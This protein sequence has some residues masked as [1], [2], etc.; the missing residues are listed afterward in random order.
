LATIPRQASATDTEVPVWLTPHTEL[1]VDA[2]NALIASNITIPVT[3]KP[4]GGVG[5]GVDV[6]PSGGGFEPFPTFPTIGG[7]GGITLP[8]DYPPFGT[9]GGPGTGGG[10][11]GSVGGGSG[12]G[13][14]GGGGGGVSSGGSGGG[15]F[16]MQSVARFDVG[17]PD[18]AFKDF[19]RETLVALHGREAIVP[20]GY[21]RTFAAKHGVA[22]GGKFMTHASNT[23]ESSNTTSSGDATVVVLKSNGNVDDDLDRIVRAA[24]Q[25]AKNKRMSRSKLRR[26]L[27]EGKV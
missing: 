1:V 27:L 12:G 10:G 26:A 24:P 14:F 7:P 6:P 23:F 4:T 13:G 5:G 19:G 15:G 17:T 25:I 8:I 3:F 9:I 11:G 16:T 18:L 21:E 20:E 22:P 2:I